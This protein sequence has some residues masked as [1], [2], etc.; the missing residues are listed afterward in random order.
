MKP[1]AISLVAF[2]AIAA[3]PGV[4]HAQPAPGEYDTTEIELLELADVARSGRIVPM[5]LHVPVGAGPFPV[6]I[7]SHGAGG[8]LNSNFAQAH[9][10]ATHGYLAV[11]LEHLGSNTEQAAA[12]G[13]RVG[14][15]IAAMTRNA[16]EVLGR[17]KD[18]SFA[19]DQLTRLDTTHPS[20]QGKSDVNR[21]GMMGHSF[22]AYTTL[23]VCGARPALDWL[24]PKVGSGQGLGPDLS[25]KRVLCGVALSPQ[26]P[27]E[28]FFLESSYRSIA[29]PLLG[30]SGSLDKQQGFVPIH[31]KH[32]FQYWPSGDR[33]L[34]W[35]N[36]AA[37][38]HF[39]DST[40]SKERRL[41][42]ANNRQD[43]VQAVSRAAT[44]LFLD[45]YLK[46]APGAKLQEKDLRSH[47][48]GIVDKIE[49]LV[50]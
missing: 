48:V 3:F 49:L 33:Y 2:I 14:K 39:S 10:L 31:R 13:L 25:D 7:V 42:F 34:L 21:I 46:K 8:N 45:Q 47:M 30:I 11:C 32:S 19:I 6:V 27:G 40:G 4:S 29:V 50:K 17:P 37:H 36:N 23:A 20:L 38:L 44:L 41:N 35:I 22:G 18:V 28:P 9:H 5:K 15:T 16:G 1:I 26:G 24:D 12:G 43:D